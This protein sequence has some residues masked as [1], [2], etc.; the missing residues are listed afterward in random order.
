M[1]FGQLKFILTKGKK[2]GQKS[3]FFGQ[4]T[5]TELIYYILLYLYLSLCNIWHLKARQKKCLVTCLNARTRKRAMELNARA[6]GSHCAA[7]AKP[8]R[9]QTKIQRWRLLQKFGNIFAGG[10]DE[11]PPPPRLGRRTDAVRR[12]CS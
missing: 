10:G 8:A 5:K 9:C 6:D 7:V 2:K 11:L 1:T 12:A 3:E 4:M